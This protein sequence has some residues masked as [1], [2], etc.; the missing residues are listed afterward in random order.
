[1]SISSTN[2]SAYIQVID[3]E[4]TSS[5]PSLPEGHTQTDIPEGYIHFTFN[6]NEW[7]NL[8]NEDDPI[9]YRDA[10]S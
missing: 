3:D 7:C 10:F 5:D 9:L 6:E 2:P 1:M 8:S 4:T